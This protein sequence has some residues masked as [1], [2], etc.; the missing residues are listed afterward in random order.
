MQATPTVS[1]TDAGGIFKNAAFPATAEVLGVE[2]A[3]APILEGIVPALTYYIGTYNTAAQ[4]AGLIPLAAAPSQAGFYTVVARFPGSADYSAALSALVPFTIT[5]AD[6]KVILVRHSV[7]KGKKVVSVR[8]TAEVEPLSPGAGIPGGI[9]RFTANKKTLA[10][11][12]L[13]RG[14]ATLTITGSSAL[15]QAVTVIYSG[16]HD[17]QP[18]QVGTP[19]LAQA[20]VKSLGAPMI[21]RV[22]RAS[23][24]AFVRFGNSHH[25]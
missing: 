3:R 13:S 25:E 20:S 17:F 11:S 24:F 10:A 8:L 21:K 5:R 1:V 2:G 18:S 4:I 23:P 7:F 6:T 19:V 16:D 9:V 14:Q 22:E 15:K 12:R